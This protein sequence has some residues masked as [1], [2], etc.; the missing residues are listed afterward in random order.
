ME[1]FDPDVER[2]RRLYLVGLIWAELVFSLNADEAERM[3]IAI[4][5][6]LEQELAS[7]GSCLLTTGRNAEI[8]AMLQRVAE[9]IGIEIPRCA[10]FAR[11][12]VHPDGNGLWRIG[13]RAE[14]AFFSESLRVNRPLPSALA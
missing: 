6:E 9:R 13:D 4:L 14:D 3:A 1:N 5:S 11:F 12:E 10:P 2:K 7:K 8:P